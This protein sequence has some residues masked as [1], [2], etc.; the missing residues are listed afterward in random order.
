MENMNT[1]KTTKPSPD[2]DTFNSGAIRNNLTTLPWAA[3]PWGALKVLAEVYKEGEKDYPKD[4]YRKGIPYRNLVDHMMGHLQ[5]IMVGDF[6]EHDLK[7]HASK[8]AWAAHTMAEQEIHNP[9]M[10][11]LWRYED[12]GG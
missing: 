2:L 11:D 7:T 9:S 4:N 3:M 6:S 1:N 5:K 10:N 12:K 8:I